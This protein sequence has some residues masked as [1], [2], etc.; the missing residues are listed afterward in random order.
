MFYTRP[1]QVMHR[2]L[3]EDETYDILH[4]CHDEPCG[5]HF[6]EKKIALKILTT[7]YYW[8]TLQNHVVNYT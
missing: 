6:A 5:G 4:A 2:C 1:N 7:G 3:R 8:P